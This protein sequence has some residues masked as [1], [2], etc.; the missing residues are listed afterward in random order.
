MKFILASSSPRR[1]EILSYLRVPFRVQSADVDETPYTDESPQ[2]LVLRLSREKA[3][4]TAWRLTESNGLVL[5][6]DTI[7]AL[8]GEIIGKPK[9]AADAKVILQR[10]RARAHQVF[11]GTTLLSL[12]WSLRAKRASEGIEDEGWSSLCETLVY[13]RDYSAAEIQNYIASGSPCDKAGAY[14]IQDVEFHPVE[15]IVGCYLNVMGLPLC[16]VIRGLKA[17]DIAIDSGEPF[18]HDCIGQNGQPCYISDLK[19]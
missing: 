12:G 6:A 17:M 11:T 7:V 13:M 4:A 5:A 15:R 19:F 14:A 18:L 1:K 3:A 2:D 10:L 9:D 8:D 16:E